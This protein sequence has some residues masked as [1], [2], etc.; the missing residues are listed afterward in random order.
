MTAT[1]TFKEVLAL[2][3]VKTA[4]GKSADGQSFVEGQFL[5]LTD[6]GATQICTFRAA[7]E[8]FGNGKERHPA[9]IL[10]RILAKGGRSAHLRGYFEGGAE[11]NKRWAKKAFVVMSAEAV[12]TREGREAQK[13]KAERERLEEQEEARRKRAWQ[14]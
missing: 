12:E 3:L 14:D 13:R 5:S 1:S 8:D 7:D 2:S 9:T 4:S 10:L 6:G 11:K